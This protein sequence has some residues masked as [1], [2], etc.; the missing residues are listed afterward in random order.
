M[1]NFK[2]YSLFNEIEDN[3]LRTRNR[4]VLMTNIVEQHFNKG[5][6]TDKGS[7]LVLGYFNQVPK[8]ERAALHKAF[9]SML[10][11]R[12]FKRKTH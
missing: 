6:I 3:S 4:A 5:S 2:G 9:S 10:E 11:D 12:G 8:E 1:D 7:Y